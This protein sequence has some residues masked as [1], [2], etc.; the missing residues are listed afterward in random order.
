MAL[1]ISE[2]RAEA[3][4]NDR[5]EWKMKDSDLE[6]VKENLFEEMVKEKTGYRKVLRKNKLPAKNLN[7]VWKQ[8]CKTKRRKKNRELVEEQQQQLKQQ[9]QNKH[10]S[11]NCGQKFDNVGEWQKKKN[12]TPS[13]PGTKGA[14]VY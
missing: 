5:H 9:V 12:Q 10:K 4:A 13:D 11:L 1:R 6:D 8:F 14:V 7:H 3:L 2:G